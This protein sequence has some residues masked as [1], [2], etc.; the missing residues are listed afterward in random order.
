MTQ[1]RYFGIVFLFCFIHFQTSFGQTFTMPS[2][3]NVTASATT[4][5]GTFVDNG[6]SGNYS[7]NQKTKYIICPDTPGNKVQV[8]FTNFRI[9]AGFDSLLI[10]DRDNYTGRS[11]TEPNV[12]GVF[13][14]TNNPGTRT[15][16]HASGCLTFYFS[17]DGSVVFPGWSATFS[18][19]PACT[20]ADEDGFD[21]IACGGTDCNDG[22]A[23]INPG[24]SEI[25]CNGIDEN[26]NG[27]DDDEPD[28]VMPSG[29]NV[30]SSTNT[31]CGTF[32]DHGGSGNYPNNQKT[33]YI[34]CP[35]T[36]GD[37]VQV[38]FTSFNIEAG[39]DSLLIINR[40]DYT[41][42]SHTEPNVMGVFWG[43]NNP[44]TRTSTH[45][46]GCLTFYFS[47]DG[48]VVK[49]GWSATFSCVPC[50]APTAQCKS[51][52]V[53][54][55]GSGSGTLL[56]ADVDNNSTAPCG[57]QSLSVTPDVFNCTDVGDN[58]V[59]LTVGDGNGNQNTCTA[60]VTVEDK[61]PPVITCQDV[62]IQLDAT[63]NKVF[64]V[65]VDGPA[66]VSQSDNCALQGGVFR[67]GPGNFTCAQVGDFPITIFKNDVNGNQTTCNITLTI[68][69]NVA[70]DAICQDITVQL[71]ATGNASITGSDIDGGSTDAC[72][73]A[74]LSANPNTFDCTDVGANTSTLT[75]TDNNGN[76]NTCTAN[77]TVE[78]NQP[79]IAVCQD[80]T[81]NLTSAGTTSFAAALVDGGS[82]TACGT[83]SLS[84]APN[85][86]TC[87]D[88]GTQTV[89][90]TV[91]DDSNNQTDNCTATVTVAD[92][93]SFC[94][95]PP[96]AVCNDLT[97]QLDANGDASVTAAQV[98]AG[99]TAD[100]G[101]LSETVTSDVFNCGDVGIN[102]VTYTITDIKNQSDNCTAT[103][104][105]E[106]RVAPT[107]LCQDVT[108]QLD[109]AGN[110]S[111]TA[112][113]VDNGSNDA[114]G[115]A[116]LTLTT[117]GSFTCDDKGTNTVTITVTDVNGN[118]S[119]CTATAT[120]ED[121]VPPT[122]TECEGQFAIFNGEDEMD[123]VPAIDF[124]ATDACGLAGTTY[125]PLVI[126]CDQL[127]T[128]VEVAITVM[129]VNGNPSTCTTTI[130]VDGLPC[131]FMD[132]GDD[133][134]GCEDS[135]EAS[136]D[137]PSETFTLESDGCYTTNFNQDNAAYVKAELCGDG[138][139]IAHVASINPQG[140]G[141]AGISM[142]ES[143]APGSKKVELLVNLSNF[144]RRAVRTTT[145]GVA[146]P[147]QFFR[148]QATWLRIVRTGNQFVGYASTN[149]VN[150]QV[151]M[152]AN[153]P[154]NACIQAGLVVTNYNAGNV[155][156]SFDNVEVNEY[157]N[158]NLQIPDTDNNVPE[159]THAQDF[160]FFPNPV[161]S[162]LQVDLSNFADQEVE[163]RMYN[164]VGQVILQNRIEAAAHLPKKLDMN[165]LSSGTYFIEVISGEYR[166]V[167]KLLKAG[168]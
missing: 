28:L 147:A 117:P 87:D 80:I 154:M 100:C 109:A 42:R 88:L 167:K 139:I 33:K 125:S 104:T 136:Y 98:G 113:A 57:L 66:L 16:T 130:K 2:G 15:S 35:N 54:L 114:C 69:D 67:T 38:T 55:D 141:W 165:Q 102:T 124:S 148:P 61:L 162:E 123:V 29:V 75:V 9:E 151:V 115:V 48:S 34:V 73:I 163:I 17:S 164:Q 51:A 127:G 32:V 91:T 19:V 71:D 78:D 103:I 118:S 4:C 82:S 149:G 83:F 116:G 49:P 25:F 106:D 144:V 99:S 89:T 86:F 129:D 132:F 155:V 121:N 56:P 30:V 168:Q 14:G 21:D 140:Q 156:A 22:D 137:I 74:S 45:S 59:T 94:C 145:N 18:C 90:L 161:T 26:C 52:T 7:T 95:D 84:V 1:N 138:E 27:L 64:N 58:T 20:D 46:S 81:L 153:V 143:E 60:T 76:S 40:N 11:H 128:D 23:T 108:V 120:V 37:R 39:F 110:G 122:I 97:V 65:F 47:A 85:G 10:I 166:Q 13:W 105:I 24:A 119:N 3:L 96:A 77:V 31:C 92:P 12:I 8:T 43:T 53:Q 36:P 44:G 107:A 126:T 41:G 150:W 131:G 101:L 142:R 63:G 146:Y 70:P 62:T 68:E 133:G 79:P 158:A 157:N 72:G 93:N 6:G 159:I 134:I 5:S 50:A 160:S 112:E 152:T 111:T 135:N